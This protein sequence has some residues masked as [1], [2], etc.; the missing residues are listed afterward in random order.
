MNELDERRVPR[1]GCAGLIMSKDGK[2]L[3]MGKRAKDPG[4][5]LWVLPGG[6]IQWGETF[7]ETLKREIM[8][9]AGIEIQVLGQFR[10]YE[11]IDPPNQHR[12][13]LYMLGFAVEDNVVPK[14]SS[15]LSEVKFCTMDELLK[16]HVEGQLSPF[17]TKIIADFGAAR[18][19]VLKDVN[20]LAKA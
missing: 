15:D 6:G 2:D 4:R 11:L 10:A 17:I 9:E 5:G 12:V 13:I 14:P 8:E 19:V 16:M 7:N 20:R 18:P 1:L 3:L